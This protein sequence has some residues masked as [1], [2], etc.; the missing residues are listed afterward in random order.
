MYLPTVSPEVAWE[1][2]SPDACVSAQLSVVLGFEPAEPLIL[3]QVTNGNGTIIDSK[4]NFIMQPNL[5]LSHA[6]IS[7]EANEEAVNVAN[8]GP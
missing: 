3:G 2:G 4:T 8:V 1:R 7:D 6:V 5:S